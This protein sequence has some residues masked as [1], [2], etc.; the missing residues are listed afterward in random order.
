MVS[1]RNHYDKLVIDANMQVTLA[2]IYKW[3]LKKSWWW[4]DNIDLFSSTG[5]QHNG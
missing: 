1:S 3:D 2:P 5:L 4:H